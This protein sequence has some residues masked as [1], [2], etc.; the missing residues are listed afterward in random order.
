MDG[1]YW[2]WSQNFG[3]DHLCNPLSIKMKKYLRIT[4]SLN[5]KPKSKY[6]AQECCDL[7][8]VM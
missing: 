7:A 4:F 5:K 3:I 2:Y 1:P 6:E 8:V